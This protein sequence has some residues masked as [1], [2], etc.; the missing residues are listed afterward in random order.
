MLYLDDGGFT[1]CR[2]ELGWS[3]GSLLDHVADVAGVSVSPKFLEDEAGF[4]GMEVDLVAPFAFFSLLDF[5][6]PL[7]AASSS[8]AF[9]G[10]FSLDFLVGP[11]SDLDLT[12]LVET[13]ASPVISTS[14]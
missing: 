10:F 1:N 4:G 13:L 5:L 7:I 9:F 6:E 8:C 14:G 2:E 12:F 3:D 11:C